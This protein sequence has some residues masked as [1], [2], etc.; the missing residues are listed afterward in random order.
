M[1]WRAPPLELEDR[2]LPFEFQA[3]QE[4]ERSQPGVQLRR[5]PRAREALA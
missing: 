3:L 2:H 1:R 4:N 5:S